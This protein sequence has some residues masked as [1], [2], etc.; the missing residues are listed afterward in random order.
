MSVAEITILVKTLSLHTVKVT[1][2]LPPPPVA[3]DATTVSAARL[4]SAKLSGARAFLVL[5]GRHGGPGVPKAS[6]EPNVC[7]VV[8]RDKNHRTLKEAIVCD[9]WQSAKHLVMNDQSIASGTVFH[10][11]PSIAEARAYVSE[12]KLVWPSVSGA[13]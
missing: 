2:V 12:A 7:W 3:E 1:V 4:E 5:N 10:A 9:S 11:W 6:G 13:Q 8:L